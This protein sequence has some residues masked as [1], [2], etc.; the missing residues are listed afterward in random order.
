M[1]NLNKSRFAIF[2]SAVSIML[3]VS[4]LVTVSV[5]WFYFPTTQN[6]TIYTDVN[7]EIGVDLYEYRSGQSLFT[8][9]GLNDAQD[10]VVA[11][12][13]TTTTFV[14]WGGVFYPTISFT[15]YYMLILTYPDSNFLNGYLAADLRMELL[16]GM[17][18]NGDSTFS[19]NA[20]VLYTNIAYAIAADADLDPLSAAA[21]TQAH[22][23]AYTLLFPDTDPAPVIT[24][25]TALDFMDE[26]QLSISLLDL[27]SEQYTNTT[28]VNTQC[29]LILFVRIQSDAEHIRDSIEE[30]EVP[31][32]VVQ[33]ATSNIYTFSCN[34]R[35]IPYKT[36]YMDF[37]KL[38]CIVEERKDLL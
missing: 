30:N 23:A 8:Q 37:K 6:V 18:D 3:L 27:G 33:I 2:I 24:E 35:S 10:T 36:E 12:D 5:A 38:Y 34:F 1:R 7:Y 17:H 31:V 19:P 25:Q 26:D 20:K 29:R 32:N 11:N 4:L 13:G 16:S 22:S 28:S 21:V 9:A 15:N 14:E